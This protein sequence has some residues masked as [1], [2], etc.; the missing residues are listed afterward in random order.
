MKILS[1]FSSLLKDGNDDQWSSTRFT[2]LFTVLLSNICIFGVWAYIC[3][4]TKQL[5]LFPSEIITMYCLANGITLSGKVIQ[6][7][8]ELKYSKKN[9]SSTN[10]AV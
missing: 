3:I 1:R 10:E 2:L 7:R 6:T 8:H 4:Q 5:I 9:K